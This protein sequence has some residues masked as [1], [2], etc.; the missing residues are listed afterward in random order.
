MAQLTAPVTQSTSYN[1]VPSVKN[2]LG[3]TSIEPGSG[4][5]IATQT[6]A[7]GQRIAFEIS[8]KG[9]LALNYFQNSNEPGIGLY[10][11]VC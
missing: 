4:Y 7:A 11:S 9:N 3:T 5:V 10:I 2:D 1:T 8:A 6:C